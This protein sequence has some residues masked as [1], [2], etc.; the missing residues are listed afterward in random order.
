MHQMSAVGI[1]IP[2]WNPANSK[3]PTL[4]TRAQHSRYRALFILLIWAFGSLLL[5]MQKVHP[6]V[7]VS[8]ESDT[9]DVKLLHEIV[10]GDNTGGAS[11]VSPQPEI[12]SQNLSDATLSDKSH[13]QQQQNEKKLTAG[14]DDINRVSDSHFK[15]DGFK[16]CIHLNNATFNLHVPIFNWTGDASAAA[17]TIDEINPTSRQFIEFMDKTGEHINTVLQ[18]VFPNVFIEEQTKR[19]SCYAAADGS[20]ANANL[21]DF[22]LLH[23]VDR[24][25]YFE[26]ILPS[27]RPQAPPK[28]ASPDS[29]DR[30]K[31]EYRHLRKDGSK[32]RYKVAYLLMVHGSVEQLSGITRLIEELDDGSAAILVHID[33]NEH[34][35]DLRNEIQDF[36]TLREAALMDRD[37]IA[38]FTKVGVQQDSFNPYS[39]AGNVFIAK[40]SYE[41]TWGHGSI[42][43]V[44]MN[45]FFELLDLADW[46]YV[47]NMS[48]SD[49]PM[50]KSREIHRVLTQ[51]EYLG[52]SL[53]QYWPDDFSFSRRLL[54]HLHIRHPK[55]HDITVWHMN[56]IGIMVPPFPRW[57]FVKHHQW[58]ILARDFVDHLRDSD[59]VALA[60][61]YWEN[62]LIP[63]ESFFGTV[64]LNTPQFSNRIL[65]TNKRFLKFAKQP[66]SHPETLSMKHHKDIGKELRGEDPK[67]L[68]MRKVNHTLNTTE[69]LLEWISKYHIRRH[70]GDDRSY[71]FLDG[72]QFIP[73]NDSMRRIR[74]I[75]K[76]DP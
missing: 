18:G 12:H 4:R 14:T 53:I 43:W 51:P 71:G 66:A 52:N 44:Q 70:L 47:I 29:K 46:D 1:S 16:Y 41:V 54:P 2:P 55:F 3:A 15:V 10:Q 42:V 40:K 5:T 22:R 20:N 49:W 67:Y 34:S 59:Q 75:K 36:I 26:S 17:K 65:N 27:I 30:L 13:L 63:D 48:A 72:L 56:Q 64:F 68:F 35:S 38:N 50:R 8:P 24:F 33:A 7:P 62:M 23:S 76:L 57:R 58:M 39:I 60:L 11:K 69:L 25:G 37:R 28:D 19:F 31:N 9:Q 21:S 74:K 61:A 73:G 32:R 6:T 45:G